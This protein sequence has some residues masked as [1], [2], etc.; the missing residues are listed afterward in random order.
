LHAHWRRPELHRRRPRHPI[1]RSLLRGMTL[2][3]QL[4][5]LEVAGRRAETAARHVASGGQAPVAVTLATRCTPAATTAAAAASSLA[6]ATA[7]AAAAA[8]AAAAAAAAA[9]AGAGARAGA[10]RRQ[11]CRFRVWSHRLALRRLRGRRLLRLLRLLLLRLRLRAGLWQLTWRHVVGPV[12]CMYSNI[13]GLISAG[14]CLTSDQCRA[15]VL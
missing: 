1:G 6:A 7:L 14:V 4:P 11:R 13:R 9:A 12:D 5:R 3:G 8:T 2:E 15:M 10:R